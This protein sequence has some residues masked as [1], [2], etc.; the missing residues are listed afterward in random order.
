MRIATWNVNSIRTRLERVLA[1]AQ[2]HQLDVLAMQEIKCRDDQFPAAAF[3]AAGYEVATWGTNQWNGVA[4][5]SRVGLD[6]VVR[7][8]PGQ[9]AWGKDGATPVVEPRALRAT[10]AGIDIWSLYVPNGREL[11]DPHYTYKLQWYAALREHLAATHTPTR[12]LLAVGDFNVAPL[13]QDVWDP[14][15][16]VD[17]THTSPAE[18]AAFTA[19][20]TAD[21][22]ELT[23]PHVDGYTYWDYQKLRF[24]KNEGMRIDFALGSPAVAARVTAVEIDREER[25][26]KGASDHVPVILTLT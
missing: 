23:R 9:P 26:G 11:T 18:R 14:Q 13:D 7:G 4:I 16:F 22:S 8:F 3:T 21:L 2:R 5:A 24:P 20:A 12:Q 25:K 17:K 19:L 1:A 15:Y 6:D 10:C